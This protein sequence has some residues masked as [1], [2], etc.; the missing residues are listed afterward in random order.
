MTCAASELV[1]DVSALGPTAILK[2]HWSEVT[3][4][5]VSAV[6][7][8]QDTPKSTSRLSLKLTTPSTARSPCTVALFVTDRLPSVANSPTDSVPTIAALSPT[9]RSSPT[10]RSLVV[11]NVVANRSLTVTSSPVILSGADSVYEPP[12]APSMQSG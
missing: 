8:A 5:P 3:K 10:N 4:L 6:S 1:N 2:S 11:V 7:E 12:P 9:S